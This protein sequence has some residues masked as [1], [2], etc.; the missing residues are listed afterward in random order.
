MFYTAPPPPSL[1]VPTYQGDDC[2]K[3]SRDCFPENTQGG[4][5]QASTPIFWYEE[6]A[7]V[8]QLPVTLK[9]VHT[10]I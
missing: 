2:K 1:P 4:V 10:L 3:G 7:T 9:I 6:S 5:V 8:S